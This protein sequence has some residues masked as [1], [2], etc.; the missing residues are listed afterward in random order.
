[1]GLKAEKN[2][3]KKRRKNMKKILNQIRNKVNELAVRANCPME[4]KTAEGYIDVGVKIIIAVVV[5]AVI[6][7][8]LYALFDNVILPRL[9]TEIE[10]M[11]DY[12]A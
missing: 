6:L 9:N 11:F 8:G 1:M 7:G 2:K 5:G 3:T 12:T 10:A 4:S